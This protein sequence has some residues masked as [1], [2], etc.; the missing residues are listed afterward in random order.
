M[1][2]R[3][4]LQR[5]ARHESGA[6]PSGSAAAA[7]LEQRKSG[8]TASA[9]P[10]IPLLV[11]RPPTEETGRRDLLHRAKVGVSPE[12]TGRAFCMPLRCIKRRNGWFHPS[13]FTV[14][15]YELAWV[16]RRQE[17]T[18][19]TPW[20]HPSTSLHPQSVVTSTSTSSFKVTHKALS[21]SHNTSNIFYT[22]LDNM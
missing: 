7:L 21:I 9:R 17:R 22:T 5:S 12:A 19:P 1:L 3:S 18:P 20:Q 8:A 6:A 10:T 11:D 16:H 13:L 14:S 4:E 15:R 2:D